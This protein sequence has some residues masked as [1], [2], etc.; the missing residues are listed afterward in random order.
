MTQGGQSFPFAIKKGDDPAAKA[1]AALEGFDKIVEN[2]L[3]ALQVPGIAMAVVKDDKVIY[4]KG[5]GYKD[6]ENKV[7]AIPDTIFAIG[8]ASKA[9]TVFAL[10]KLVD[11]GKVEWDK[12][13][14][15]YIPWFRLYDQEAGERLTPRDLVTHRSGLPR[16][17]LVW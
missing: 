11:E 13:V 3:T 14:R 12:P 9:F 16:H 4:A 2:G 7:P 8:S 15:T 1:L 5:F 6:V 10:G 17:D